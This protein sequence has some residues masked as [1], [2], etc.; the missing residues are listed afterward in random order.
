MYDFSVVAFNAFGSVTET[1]HLDVADSSAL[2]LWDNFQSSTNGLTT[3]VIWATRDP[4]TPP[5]YVTWDKHGLLYNRPGFTGISP[6]NSWD[7][8]PPG[9][10]TGDVPV[11]ALTRRHGYCRGHGNGVT[12]PWDGENTAK[13]FAYVWFCDASDNRVQMYVRYAYT[14]YDA[15]GNDYT[16]LFFD[17][18][19]PGNITPLDVVAVPASYAVCL[20]TYSV[21]NVTSANRL[22]GDWCGYSYVGWPPFNQC[23][24]SGGAS[25]SPN[26]LPLMDG[27]LAVVAFTATTGPN[28][29]PMQDDMDT[30]TTWA[31]LSPAN[32]QMDWHSYP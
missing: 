3:P 22:P 30:M 24:Y 11:T 27:T 19:L 8:A 7:V 2:G 32:Y 29:H 16:I 10:W 9:D 18:D 1:T 25:G 6:R 23:T 4:N 5:Q 31:G 20:R 21:A 12:Y 15:S 17:Q 13:E 26:M 28:V 14:R